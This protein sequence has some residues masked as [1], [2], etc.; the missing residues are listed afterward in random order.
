VRARLWLQG[1]EGAACTAVLLA[2]WV[3]LGRGTNRAKRARRR[4]PVLKRSRG[5]L[6]ARASGRP[7][8][9]GS[10]PGAGDPR[11]TASRTGRLAACGAAA[12]QVHMIGREGSWT[13]N[14]CG[15]SGT[16]ATTG[17]RA[18]KGVSRRGGPPR[19]AALC[20]RLGLAHALKGSAPTS[21]SQVAGPMRPRVG[22]R[23][24]SVPLSH[25]IH[26][27]TQGGRPNGDPAATPGVGPKVAAQRSRAEAAGV[28]GG[29]GRGGGAGAI[30]AGRWGE[31]SSA[32]LKIGLLA[33]SERSGAM[34]LFVQRHSKLVGL[35]TFQGA[36]SGG[37][38]AAAGSGEPA[39]R[40]AA[41]RAAS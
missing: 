24:A 27:N 6:G 22:A 21:R 36:A 19:A 34:R 20:G 12:E 13:A 25:L 33:S 2:K 26:A 15:Q 10:R 37:G 39:G 32:I 5:R 4:F 9:S 7:S 8:G 31:R 11:G 14:G 28:C 40:G 3:H 38:G 30:A 29:K 16:D 35:S 41:C 17:R 1:R 23:G 18:R